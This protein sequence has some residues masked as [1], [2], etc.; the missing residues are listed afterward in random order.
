MLEHPEDKLEVGSG[1]VG[2]GHPLGVV[3]EEPCKVAGSGGGVCVEGRECRML[4]AEC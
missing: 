3:G 1:D 2:G 4:S